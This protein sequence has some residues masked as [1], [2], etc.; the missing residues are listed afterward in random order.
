M[1][2]TIFLRLLT[3]TLLLLPPQP[4]AS[5]AEPY[6]TLE[7]AIRPLEEPRM[8]R[9]AQLQQRLPVPLR[10]FESDGCSGGLSTGWQRLVDQFPELAGRLGDRPP[11]ETCCVEHDRAYWRGQGVNGYAHRLAADRALRQCVMTTAEANREEWATRL[12][13][14]P[15]QL[16]D[17][18]TGVAQ[19]MYLA[20]RVAGGPCTGLDWRWGYGWPDCGSTAPAGEGGVIGVGWQPPKGHPRTGHPSLSSQ[21]TFAPTFVLRAH[22]Q[23]TCPSP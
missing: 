8:A 13:I 16:D 2:I 14:S 6:A 4:G 12:G 7:T 9:L 1:R 15:A 10:A 3:M 18:M 11:W 17:L 20:V 19:A 23:A 5:R 21:G 22:A